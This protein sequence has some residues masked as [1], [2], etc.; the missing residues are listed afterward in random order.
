M[1][2]LAREPANVSAKEQETEDIW[3]CLF[4]DVLE[5]FH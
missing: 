3:Y 1:S 5:C 4:A 2:D